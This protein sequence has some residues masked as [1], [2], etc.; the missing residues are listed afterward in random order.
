M[1][2]DMSDSPDSGKPE[3]LGSVA[4]SE[5]TAGEVSLDPLSQEM[6]V[7]RVRGALDLALSPMLG[8]VTDRAT[9]LGARVAIVDLTGVD[10]LASRGMAEL[11]RAQV[12][13]REHGSVIRVVAADRVVLRPLML[14]RLIDEF[15]IYPTVQDAVTGR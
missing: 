8:Q 12:R 10:F 13:L 6:V 1:L 15:D 5:T 4:P 9:R 14:T 11:L 2:S 7:L 3:R